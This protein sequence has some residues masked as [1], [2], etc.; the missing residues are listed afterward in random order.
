M[1]VERIRVN[2]IA[3]P[4]ASGI[5][6][7]RH[8]DE[9]GRIGADG[10]RGAREDEAPAIRIVDR[11]GAVRVG[12]RAVET[13]PEQAEGH[14]RY[15]H[16]RA[17]LEKNL[18]V[19]GRH[20]M[21]R[22]GGAVAVGRDDGLVVSQ[23]REAGERLGRG[24]GGSERRLMLRI[25]RPAGN[26][27]HGSARARRGQRERSGFRLRHGRKFPAADMPQGVDCAGVVGC[28]APR[29]RFQDIGGDGRA[30]DQRGRRSGDKSPHPDGTARAP[31]DGCWIQRYSLPNCCTLRPP[32]A[33]DRH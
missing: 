15:L 24:F 4:G 27:L 2:E 10:V 8:R 30:A 23:S 22:P 16:P 17:V 1:G 29:R 25:E 6:R 11:P 12:V 5:T 21:V 7:L 3:V 20:Q 28:C 33:P 19:Q 32:K 9:Q 13:G 14:P 31:S 18:A 26:R